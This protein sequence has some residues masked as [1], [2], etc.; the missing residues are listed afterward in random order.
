MQPQ[1]LYRRPLPVGRDRRPGVGSLQVP[2]SLGASRLVAALDAAGAAADMECLARVLA[3]LTDHVPR[4]VPHAPLHAQALEQARAELQQLP[5][6]TGLCAAVGGERAELAVL[7][8]VLG[9]SLQP[10][11]RAAV[12]P[13]AAHGDARVLELNNRRAQVSA[14]THLPA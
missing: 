6:F 7:L 9:D 1:T 8:C 11:L 5:A 12:T 3:P 10:A 14:I 2:T 13:S 4:R